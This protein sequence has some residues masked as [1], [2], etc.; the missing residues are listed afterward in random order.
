MYLYF[1]Y[2]KTSRPVT[3][4]VYNKYFPLKK[5]YFYVHDI[6]DVNG[7]AGFIESDGVLQ[8]EQLTV[9]AFEALINEYNLSEGITS[10]ECYLKNVSRKLVH[11]DL[12]EIDIATIHYLSPIVVKYEP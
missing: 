9:K 4:V 10:D 12:L 8:V 3:K 2:D 11:V 7:D 6:A 1:R 5:L